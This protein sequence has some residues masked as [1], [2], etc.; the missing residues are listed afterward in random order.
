MT[1]LA[2]TSEPGTRSTTIMATTS[3]AP[4]RNLEAVRLTSSKNFPNGRSSTSNAEVSR[5]T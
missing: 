1:C 3:R 4:G 5:T 2:P